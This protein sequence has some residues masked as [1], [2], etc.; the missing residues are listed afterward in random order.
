MKQWLAYRPHGHRVT[1]FTWP[2]GVELKIHRFEDIP[3]E[4]GFVYAPFSPSIHCPIIWISSRHLIPMNSEQAEIIGSTEE[5]EPIESRN[6]FVDRVE[7]IKQM[8]EEGNFQKVVVSRVVETD[9][10][11][12]ISFFQKLCNQYPRANVCWFQSQFTGSWVTAS[13][14]LL[15]HRRGIKFETMA[16]AGTRMAGTSG[17]WG[18]KELKEQH[19]VTA[20]LLDRLSKLHAQEVEVFGPV[21][22]NAGN[23]EH[24][25]TTLL[26]KTEVATLEMIQAL[27][28]TPAVCGYPAKEAHQFL[29]KSE[30]SFRKYYSGFFGLMNPMGESELFV[31]LRCMEV[32]HSGCRLH[33]GCGIL[34]DSDADAEFLE[35]E[36]KAATLG[37]LIG[38]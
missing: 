18:A 33:V 7:S 32:L 26:G 15:L 2:E 16:L 10:K 6:H 19:L 4:P 23:I 9:K 27:H 24:L 3:Q 28:P 12:D 38:A 36:M 1:W 14:E 34:S 31:N 35:T 13:P 37:N 17:N 25:K 21:T 22:D 29:E 8:C 20:Y 11:P 30:K 5:K